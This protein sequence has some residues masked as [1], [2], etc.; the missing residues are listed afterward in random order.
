MSRKRR[1]TTAKRTNSQRKPRSQAKVPFRKQP[2]VWIGTLVTLLAGGA[3]TAFGT[4]LGSSLFSAVH[5]ASSN[6]AAAVVTGPPVVIDSVMADG[7]GAGFSYVLPQRLILTS[8]QLNSLNN[9]TPDDPQYDQWFTSRGGAVPSPA[10]LKLV[11]EGN[12]PH[13]VLIIDMGVID[14]CTSALT[15]TLFRNGSNGGSIGD[16]AVQFDLDLPRPVPV[17]G[18]AGGSYFAAH[19]ISLEKGEQAVFQIAANSTRYC[20]YQIALTVVDGTKTLTETVSDHGQPFKVTGLLPETS[21]SA[22]YVGATEPGEAAPFK[23]ENSAT[24]K[25]S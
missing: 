25:S 3:A 17:N 15:G 20:Q 21:Y 2:L 13:P 14:H 6:A 11:V 9:L 5:N 1:S 16:L 4:G 10:L 22:L 24:S 7:E 18:I 19:S 23:R 8:P 12:R